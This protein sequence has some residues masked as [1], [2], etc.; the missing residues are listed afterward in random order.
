MT[1]TGV[2]TSVNEDSGQYLQHRMIEQS[3][4][5]TTSTKENYHV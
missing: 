3:V 1:G 2:Y 5:H 4:L